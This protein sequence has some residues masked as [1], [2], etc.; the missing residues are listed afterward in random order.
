MSP[1]EQLYES[2]AEDVKKRVLKELRERDARVPVT[3]EV[4]AK[5][6][7]VLPRTIKTWRQKGSRVTSSVAT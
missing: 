6:Y 3:K 4:L 1:G 5:R 7:G 2:L